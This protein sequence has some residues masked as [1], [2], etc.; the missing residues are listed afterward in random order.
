M[1]IRERRLACLSGGGDA[2]CRLT[3]KLKSFSF[4]SLQDK[5]QPLPDPLLEPLQ[6]IQRVPEVHPQA[7]VQAVRADRLHKVPS[8][9]VGVWVCGLGCDAQLLE[10]WGKLET[11]CRSLKASAS[12]P[13]PPF[14]LLAAQPC[15]HV[16]C[17][18]PVLTAAPRFM[19]P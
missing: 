15:C 1:C 12:T 10:V 17:T 19:C 18:P 9:C 16:H 2:T 8:R 11:G 6:D 14:C 4:L 3:C 5:V 13:P 7:W